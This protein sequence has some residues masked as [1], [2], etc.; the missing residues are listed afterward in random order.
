MTARE[1]INKLKSFDD[2]DKPVVLLDLNDDT[3]L[4]HYDISEKD[5]N[6]VDGV[7]V[8]GRKLKGHAICFKNHRT[9][10]L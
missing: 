5:I 8:S 7:H 3:E 9:S 10:R 2:I 1:L 4:S 6:Y